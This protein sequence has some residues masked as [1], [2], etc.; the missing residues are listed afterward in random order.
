MRISLRLRYRACNRAGEAN[1]HSRRIES[2]AQRR[3]RSAVRNS[4]PMGAPAR[5]RGVWLTLLVASALGG[6][7]TGV[8]GRTGGGAVARL[9]AGGRVQSNILRGDYAGSATCEGCHAKIY[10]AWQGSPM[11]RMTRLPVGDAIR[12]PFAGETFH[13]KDDSATLEQKDGVRF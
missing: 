9:P 11:H 8:S 4:A 12:A 13:F 5:R 1:L 10:A 7:R 3:Y 2:A 6:C